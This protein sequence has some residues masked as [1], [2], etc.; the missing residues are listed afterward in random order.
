VTVVLVVP[1]GALV[2]VVVAGIVVVVV[3]VG[4]ALTLRTNAPGISPVK[5]LSEMVIVWGPGAVAAVV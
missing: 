1:S 4:G 5:P 2:V 3:V